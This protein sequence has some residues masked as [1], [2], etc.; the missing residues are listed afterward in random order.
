[1]PT[2]CAHQLAG[3]RRALRQVIETT[4]VFGIL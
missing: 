1:M 4:Q 2:T 3:R